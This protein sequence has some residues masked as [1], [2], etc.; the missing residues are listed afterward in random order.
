M[1]EVTQTA[2]EKVKEFF[3]SRGNTSPLR[4]FVAGIG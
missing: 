3:K 4:I 1:L 2:S